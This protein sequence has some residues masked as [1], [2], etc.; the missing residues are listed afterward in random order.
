M[1][2]YECIGT[3]LVV[4]ATCYLQARPRRGA[5]RRRCFIE[6]SH[7]VADSVE[8]IL[9]E[10]NLAA[11]SEGRLF[12]VSADAER[13][14][15]P[16]SKLGFAPTWSP[17]EW[18][19]VFFGYESR[20][21]G[22]P[23]A[24]GNT[25]TIHREFRVYGPTV[26]AVRAFCEHAHVTMRARDR[27][28]DQ[29][30]NVWLWDARADEWSRSLVSQPRT[31]DT[32]ILAHRVAGRLQ[33]DMDDFRAA[34]AWYAEHLIPYRRGYLLHG[35]PG[36]GKTSTIRAIATR[37]KHD[38]YRVS[39]T[40]PDMDDTSL[41]TSIADVEDGGIIA[42]E[43]VDALFDGHRQRQGEFRV[44]FSGLL[45]AL[46]GVQDCKKGIVFVF[47]SN[48]PD[49]LDP[50]LRRKGRV[51]A[52]FCL[53]ACAPEQTRRMFLRFYPDE[54]AH[55]DAFVESVH[56]HSG[57]TPAELQHHFIAHRTAA[58]S[59][60]TVFEREARQSRPS[61]AMFS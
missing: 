26:E 2:S 28:R 34:R 31:F 19:G 12:D 49:A 50:A 33:Q 13:T 14:D 45:N 37:F 5:A 35:P 29:D 4:A 32:I 6:V 27:D 17:F 48:N 38:V 18:H 15:G 56:R 46:D 25:T 41:A 43:D 57:V 61:E 23:L 9:I 10:D 42:L 52:E 55:A 7:A 8:R 47:T 1:N 59:D 39:L 58:A 51:D 20:D 53:D 30:I 3:L 44:T 22:A 11:C 16:Q 36:T 54:G 60:A 24:T 21:A 40:G